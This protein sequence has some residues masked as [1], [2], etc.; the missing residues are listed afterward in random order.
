MRHLKKIAL[1]LVIGLFSLGV[2]LFALDGMLKKQG[3]LGHISSSIEAMRLR[4]AHPAMPADVIEKKAAKA[5][6]GALGVLK[7]LQDAATG[8][9]PSTDVTDLANNSKTGPDDRETYIRVAENKDA[10]LQAQLPENPDA[11]SKEIK[12]AVHEISA[13]SERVGVQATA[14]GR[15]VIGVLHDT[16]TE[17][18][19]AID[20]INAL[21][22]PDHM[23]KTILKNYEET[24]ILPEI[25]VK[26][27]R[28]PTAIEEVHR[29]KEDPYNPK[30]F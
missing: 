25:L 13:N 1:F 14:D 8:K 9:P 28:K 30:N 15:A 12:G 5:N 29:D 26:E 4:Q 22:I 6:H 7:T 27:S 24:G 17:D 21:N 11:A 2:S 23:K 10:I 16:G 18:L 3:G 20:R 19:A